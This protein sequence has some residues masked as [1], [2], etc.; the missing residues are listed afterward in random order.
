MLIK[1]MRNNAVQFSNLT[2]N[3]LP[4]VLTCTFVPKGKAKRLVGHWRMSLS[5][6]PAFTVP[7]D[8]PLFLRLMIEKAQAEVSKLMGK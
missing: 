3:G 5:G 1:I 4:L 6:N 2:Y 7:G 8:A